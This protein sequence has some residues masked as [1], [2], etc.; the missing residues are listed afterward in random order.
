MYQA[1]EPKY[2]KRENKIKDMGK[3]IAKT[4]IMQSHKQTQNKNRYMSG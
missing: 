2:G 4:S 3:D 1:P